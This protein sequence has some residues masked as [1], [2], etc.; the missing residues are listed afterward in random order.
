M[1]IF[2]RDTKVSGANLRHHSEFSLETPDRAARL[3]LSCSDVFLVG[4]R[5]GGFGS[6]FAGNTVKYGRKANLS[7]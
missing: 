3:L 7:T 6:F 4:G 5:G 1:T 2:T